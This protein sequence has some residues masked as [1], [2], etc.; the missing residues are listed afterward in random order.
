MEDATS[1]D[2]FSD[3]TKLVLA[4]RAGHLC[5]NPDCR[6]STAG[7]QIDPTKA[8]NIGVAA[9]ITAASAG[10]PRYRPELSPETRRHAGNG[11]WLCQKCAK[12]V[13][14][15]IQ[16]YTEEALRRWK[17]AAEQSALARLGKTYGFSDRQDFWLSA[18]EVEILR[19]ANLLGGHIFVISSEQLGRWVRSG[20]QDF[21]NQDDPAVAVT[22]VEALESLCGRGLARYDEGS[23]YMLTSA[24]FKMAR[25]ILADEQPSGLTGE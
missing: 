25:T 6:A 23:L 5:S 13:D 21:V 17:Q 11:I 20:P 12:L 19:W 4:A 15:D 3:R 2:D 18:E 10:G 24:G 9:H 7:P 1:R 16:R 8:V 22:Y 14:N